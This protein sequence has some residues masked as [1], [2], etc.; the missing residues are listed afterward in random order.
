MSGGQSD[1]SGN[2]DRQWFQESV[3]IWGQSSLYDQYGDAG[4]D[5]GTLRDHQCMEA[6][7]GTI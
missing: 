1:Q 5:R 7:E 4:T 2:P 3:R 6:E